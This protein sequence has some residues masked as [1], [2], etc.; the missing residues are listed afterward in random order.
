MNL[1]NKNYEEMGLH[2]IIFNGRNGIIKCN[3]N[4][5]EN[6]IKLLDS[7]KK[8]LS[9]EIKIKTISTSGTIKTLI[10]KYIEKN[11]NKKT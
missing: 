11:S 6:T 8:I 7:I 3:H 4:E 10:K 1:F 9:D 5:K 2:I